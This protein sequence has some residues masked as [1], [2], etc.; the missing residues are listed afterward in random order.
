MRK[1][2]KKEIHIIHTLKHCAYTYM[3]EP[4]MYSH[5]AY[6]LTLTLVHTLGVYIQRLTNAFTS[7][8]AESGVQRPVC[9][10]PGKQHRHAHIS[11]LS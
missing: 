7:M 8:H 11:T 6:M 10:C 1:F 3:P 2:K 4:H 9:K 5:K